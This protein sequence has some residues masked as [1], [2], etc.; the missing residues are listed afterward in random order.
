MAIS[1]LAAFAV[2]LSEAREAGELSAHE[3][4]DTDPSEAAEDWIRSQTDAWFERWTVPQFDCFRGAFR[5]GWSGAFALELTAAAES[6]AHKST[7]V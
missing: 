3:N 5:C 6:D 7:R 2:A 1:N 4:F